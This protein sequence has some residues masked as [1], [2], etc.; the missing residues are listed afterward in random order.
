M[1]TMWIVFYQ[2]AVFFALLLFFG[3][4]RRRVCPDC[5]KPLP[6]LQSPFTKTRRQWVEGGYVCP[7]CGCETDLAGK[8]VP[9]GT[10]L[11]YRSLI[12]GLGLLT[13]AAIPAV[14]LLT[15]LLRR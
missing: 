7:N 1:S 2:L 11:S 3:I 5:S 4:G 12:V 9:A 10:A 14:V 15:M 8:K 13:L 6:I